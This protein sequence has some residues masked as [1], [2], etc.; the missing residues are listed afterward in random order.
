MSI[1]VLTG[2][3]GA[4]GVALVGEAGVPLVA[5]TSSTSDSLASGMVPVRRFSVIMVCSVV[6]T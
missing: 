5:P 4:P 1:L 3:I 2:V 6:N